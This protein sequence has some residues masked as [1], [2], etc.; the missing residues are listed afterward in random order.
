M[1]PVRVVVTDLKSGKRKIN[2]F[3]PTKY[4]NQN[5]LPNCQICLDPIGVDAS[6]WSCQVCSVS[7]HLKCTQLWAKANQSENGK[8]WSC[9]NCR[10][11]FD[12]HPIYYFCF[13][14]K[15]RNPDEFKVN[16]DAPPHCCTETC[17]KTSHS[18]RGPHCN[19][20]CSSRC[21]PGHCPPCQALTS[22]FCPCGIT[23]ALVQ[24]SSYR[25]EASMLPPCKRICD[26]KLSCNLHS[27]KLTCHIGA[28]LPCSEFSGSANCYCGSQNKFFLCGTHEPRSFSCGNIC[29]K[30]F[31]CGNHF[32]SETC[33]QGECKPCPGDP[34]IFKIC[35][36]GKVSVERLLGFPRISCLD[37]VP[38]CGGACNKALSCRTL[39][40]DNSS[41]HRCLA[42]CHPPPCPPCPG[43]TVSVC[44]CCRSK[45]T[46]PCTDVYTSHPVVVRCKKV[47]NRYLNCHKHKCR[48]LC[49]D[50][51]GPL[52]HCDVICG[53]MLSCG[54]HQ[55]LRSCH[56]GPCSHCGFVYNQSLSCNCGRVVVEPP[57]LCSSPFPTCTG[58]C[59]LVCSKGHNDFHTCHSSAELCPPCTALTTRLCSNNHTYVANV[60]CSAETVCCMSLCQKALVCDHSCSRFCHIGDC[61]TP[62]HLTCVQLCNKYK[63]CGHQCNQR[64][65]YPNPCPNNLCTEIVKL[66]CNCGYRS[67][68]T[69]CP[70]YM[71]LKGYLAHNLPNIVPT[72]NAITKNCLP[73]EDR[74]FV[75]QRSV[76]MAKAFNLSLNHEDYELLRP[77]LDILLKDDLKK[78]LDES[79]E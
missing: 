48:Q 39:F 33:H 17:G 7:L 63:S 24:C 16:F 34:K 35:H 77:S 14:G 66:V 13:C 3:P 31:G 40:S 52:H 59:P 79:C 61:V 19:H 11:L 72:E 10:E 4:F 45:L 21:H 54:I 43:E 44:N 55:C 71:W 73:C 70:T 23:S 2:D 36:C 38:S 69:L 53:A 75:I 30:P 41:P 60:S 25:G 20:P 58:I 8:K 12:I 46:L 57:Y 56:P 76:A 15:T 6:I 29:N 9:P 42:S 62:G 18:S 50:K 27:C 74:C 32:C 5:T 22:L 51:T 47:C 28:C 78:L 26:K 1:K 64:C 65:H 37:P 49:C 67:N 68:L